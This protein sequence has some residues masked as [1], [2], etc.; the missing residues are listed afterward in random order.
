MYL[1]LKVAPNVWQNLGN[2]VIG[3]NNDYYRKIQP[4]QGALL[5]MKIDDFDLISAYFDGEV[6]P[7]ERRQ[8][9]ELLAKDTEAQRAYQ[10]MLGIKEGINSMPVVAIKSNITVDQILAKVEKRN[11]YSLIKKGVAVAAICL[12]A[13]SGVIFG[14]QLMSPQLAQSPEPVPLTADG[15]MVALNEPVVEIIDP[16][17]VGVTINE[18]IIPIPIKSKP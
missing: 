11:Q 2:K 12:T 13:L 18:P 8:A 1:W 9:E 3:L 10:Q 5:K 4:C 16:N 6:T 14:K 7:N 17:G 15:L